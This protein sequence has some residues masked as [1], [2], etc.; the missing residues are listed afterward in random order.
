MAN[1][2]ALTYSSLVSLMQTYLERS[3]SDVT[4]F[5][6]YAIMLCESKVANILQSLGQI[7]VARTP[8]APTNQAFLGVMQKPA[9]WRETVSMRVIDR[10]TGVSTPLYLRSYEYCRNYHPDAS[11]FG[12]PEFYADID[13]DNWFFVPT[14]SLGEY[15]LEV[16]YYER[17]PP[18]SD[19]QQTNWFT[20]NAPEVMVF[21]TLLEMTPFIK[22]D[23]R[24]PVWEAKYQEAVAALNKLDISRVTDRTTLIERR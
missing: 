15:D 20:I 14:P 23:P 1:A 12:Q 2:A 19:S 18:L 6:P 21:G 11:V 8:M 5:I 9:R 22:S 13:Y 17:V 7:A 24:I 3:D 16:E 4:D 10:V